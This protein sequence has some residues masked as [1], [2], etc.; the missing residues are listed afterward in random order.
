MRDDGTTLA[1][2]GGSPAFAEPLHV[3]RPNLGDRARFLDRVNDLLDRRWLTNDGPYV[4]ELER[5]IADYAGVDHCIAVCNATVGLD[6]AYR[7]AGLAGEV[8]VPS[9]TFVATV[10]ALAAQGVTPI[11]CDID[12]KTKTLDPALVEQ[13]ITERTTGIVGVHLFGGVCAVDQLT[14]IARE[15]GLQLLF[16]AAHALGCTSGG[17]MVGSFG[18][19]EVFSFHATKFFNSFEGGAIVTNDAA[20]AARA[21]A[22]RNFGFVST[23]EVAYLGVNGKMSEIS[24][25]M[26][27]TSLESLDDFIAVNRRNYHAY[28]RALAG[29]PGVTLFEH[30]ER[31]QRNYQYI[32]I[33]LDDDVASLDRDSLRRVLWAEN[34]LARLY[35]P[36]IHR[37]EPYRGLPVR[38]GRGLRNTE[39]TARRLLAL[40]TGTAVSTE[41]IDRVCDVIRTAVANGERVMA[42]LAAEREPAADPLAQWRASAHPA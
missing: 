40:P 38:D 30:D 42:H 25:A 20:L 6:I 29:I 5:R 17:R 19:A 32:V 37:M 1:L 14:A 12:P 33:D 39:R 28:Q 18:D 26:G 41:E 34:I 4:R 22:M 16:D 31:E 10:H 21:R 15:H 24:A 23:D 3:G 11:F 9:F 8:I 2:F 27:L 35:F 7:A 13:L 36:A